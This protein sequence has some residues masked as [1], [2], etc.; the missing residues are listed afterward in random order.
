MDESQY[1][2]AVTTEPRRAV[3][4]GLKK[5][6]KTANGLLAT[7]ERGRRTHSSGAFYTGPAMES[8]G[9]FCY[10]SNSLEFRFVY[11]NVPRQRFCSEHLAL[12]GDL[13]SVAVSRSV[14][15]FIQGTVLKRWRIG[16]GSPNENNSV[17]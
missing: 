15:S 13:G 14:V 6:N 8:S 5:L 4:D 7:P 12:S 9:K 10:L 17:P 3:K 11:G 1:W 16:L 2:T